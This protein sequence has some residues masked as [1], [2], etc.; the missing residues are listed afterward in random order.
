MS[1]TSP[2]RTS[3]RPGRITA[4]TETWSQRTSWKRATTYWV[5]WKKPTTRGTGP[6]PPDSKLK[7]AEWLRPLVYPDFHSLGEQA[8]ARLKLQAV[9]GDNE[10]DL[11]RERRSRE[12]HPTEVVTMVTDNP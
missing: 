7:G 2:S 9:L 5:I 4:S 1:T 3:P 10:A 12:R 8:D 6:M 11:D